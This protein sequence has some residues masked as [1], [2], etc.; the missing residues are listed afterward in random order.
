MKM[1]QG[2]ASERTNYNLSI[3]SVCNDPYAM[4]W[5]ITEHAV[6]ERSARLWVLIE[7]NDS[8]IDSAGDRPITRVPRG[9]QPTTRENRL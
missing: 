2:E 6:H 5:D 9:I 4:D 8:N 1:E 7:R 3:P